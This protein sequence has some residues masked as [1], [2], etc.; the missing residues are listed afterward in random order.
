VHRY[1][2]FVGEPEGNKPLGRFRGS[3]EDNIKIYVMGILWGSVKLNYVAH[4]RN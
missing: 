3:C 4:G 1:I 2:I